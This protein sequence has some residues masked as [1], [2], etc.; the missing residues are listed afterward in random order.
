MLKLISNGRAPMISWELWY[1]VKWGGGAL[2]ISWWSWCR[3]Q[4]EGWLIFWRLSYWGGDQKQ[5]KHYN[6][7]VSYCQDSRWLLTK[8]TLVRLLI[9][10]KVIYTK[11]VSKNSC[12]F[13]MS[14]LCLRQDELRTSGPDE[15]KM[16]N[17]RSANNTTLWPRIQIKGSPCTTCPSLYDTRI[18]N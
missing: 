16:I 13:N 11:T 6:S 9:L 17:L 7:W 2:L 12:K 14:S 4:W 8:T 10:P 1:M 3:V 18:L 15:P 5:S